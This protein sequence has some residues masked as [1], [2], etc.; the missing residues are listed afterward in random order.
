MYRHCTFLVT[1]QGSSAGPTVGT[2]TELLQMI[3]S[4]PLTYDQHVCRH[5]DPLKCP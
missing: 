4:L 5:V 3:Y 1:R 2:S